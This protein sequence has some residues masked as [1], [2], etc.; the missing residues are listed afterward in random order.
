M[1]R[2]RV[3]PC[4]ERS[5][6]PGEG[7]ATMRRLRAQPCAERSSEPG[8]GKATMRRLRARSC[9][10][11][12]S[13]PGEGKATMRRLRARPCAERGCGPREKIPSAVAGIRPCRGWHKSIKEDQVC[14]CRPGLLIYIGLRRCVPAGAVEKPVSAQSRPG[15]C[16]TCRPSQPRPEQKR[17][18]AAA[19][20]PR[21]QR[22]RPVRRYMESEMRNTQ[23][24]F[25]KRWVWICWN[26]FQTG[27]FH[28]RRAAVL[29]PSG[30]RRPVEKE[31]DKASS[32]RLPQD[33]R[34]MPRG[35]PRR[36]S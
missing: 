17:H 35:R 2:L 3:R 4:A 18:N 29:C 14:L 16:G 6:E 26:R 1:R 12:S 24:S 5:S 10:E 22:G 30:G 33:G 9:T 15:R 36:P 23:L 7:K 19:G 32:L 25:S 8:E 34:L 20:R 31:R 27:V 11:R 21:Y 13:E 28:R